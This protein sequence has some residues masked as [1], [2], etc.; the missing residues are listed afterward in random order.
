[1]NDLVINP[2]QQPQAIPQ[3]HIPGY[4]GS[5]G[6]RNTIAGSVDR[7]GENCRHGGEGLGITG[8]GSSP[9]AWRLMHSSAPRG[10]GL[11]W[12]RSEMLA[13][14]EQALIKPSAPSPMGEGSH[15][16]ALSV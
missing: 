7:P 13:F 2:Q 3:P 14:T 9:V 11:A 12:Q 10:S 8:A 5:S 16:F 4:C 1:M 15:G 6:V